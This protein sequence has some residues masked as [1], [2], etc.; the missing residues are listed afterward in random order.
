MSTVT[1]GVSKLAIDAKISP[2][3]APTTSGNKES[4]NYLEM[5]S[6]D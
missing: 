2:A 5:I 6:L 1:E 4:C 3:V